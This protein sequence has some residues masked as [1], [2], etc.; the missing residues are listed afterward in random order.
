MK[1]WRNQARQTLGRYLIFN[2]FQQKY[3]LMSAEIDRNEI[4]LEKRNTTIQLQNAVES[5]FIK[6]KISNSDSKLNRQ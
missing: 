1:D 3:K 6:K 5:K 4:D 2:G